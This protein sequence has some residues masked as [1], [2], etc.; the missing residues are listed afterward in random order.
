MKGDEEEQTAFRRS[1]KVVRSPVGAAQVASAAASS[2]QGDS[3]S[4]TD[5]AGKKRKDRSS[6]T[7]EKS[8][9]RV[10]QWLTRL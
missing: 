6:K 8:L 10:R 5:G 3:G 1:G 9:G 7:P 2:A 4:E